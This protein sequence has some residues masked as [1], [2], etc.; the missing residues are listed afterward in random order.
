MNEN[1][2]EIECPVYYEVD[3]ESQPDGAAEI[4]CSGK[5]SI[6]YIYDKGV[7]NAP[8]EDCSP[9]GVYIENINSTCECAD[10]HEDLIIGAVLDNIS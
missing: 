4:K 8:P 1:N 9:S 10:E 2:I 3:P 7:H 5:H 6:D